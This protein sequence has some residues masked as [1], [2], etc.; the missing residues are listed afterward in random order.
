MTHSCLHHPRLALSSTRGKRAYG[1]DIQ[2]IDSC[3]APV[4]VSP[5]ESAAIPFIQFLVCSSS[6]IFGNSMSAL[7]VFK[8][9]LLHRSYGRLAKGGGSRYEKRRGYAASF[10]LGS[11]LSAPEKSMR[12][13]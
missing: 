4:E 1:N 5:S 3:S 10:L 6:P 2:H 11:E 12:W 7:M 13:S 8:N 9:N